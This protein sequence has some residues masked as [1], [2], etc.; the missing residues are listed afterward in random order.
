[1]SDEFDSTHARD[2]TDQ[3][4][5]PSGGVPRAT[6]V[7]VI[8]CGLIGSALAR[9]LAGAG[10]PVAAWNRTHERAEALSVHGVT[11]VRDV[12]NAVEQSEFVLV[13]TLDYDSA[14][15]ALDPVTA[16]GDGRWSTSPADRRRRT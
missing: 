9:T 1:M 8:G 11:A 12:G 3:S 16:W 5:Q 10:H 7:A 15:G 13:C 14:R 2:N 4:R 6:R